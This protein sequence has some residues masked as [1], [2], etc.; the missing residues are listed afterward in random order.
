MGAVSAVLF[1]DY[2]RSFWLVLAIAVIGIAF[3]GV[4][5][6]LWCCTHALAMCCSPC[7][8]CGRRIRIRGKGDPATLGAPEEAPPLR[9]PHGLRPTDNDLYASIKNVDRKRGGR[10]HVLVAAGAHTARPAQPEGGATPRANAHGV[11]LEFTDVISASS[12]RARTQLETASTSRVH[13]CRE[14]PCRAEVDVA[15]HAT[16]YAPIDRDHP[17]GLR[18]ESNPTARRCRLSIANLTTCLAWTFRQTSLAGYRTGRG[19]SRLGSWCCCCACRSPDDGSTPGEW[20]D[21][22]SESE[23]EP[24][25]TR[26]QAHLV[27]CA[28][29]SSEATGFTSK[30]CWDRALTAPT[31]L[32]E[33]DACA[34]GLGLTGSEPGTARLCHCHA[35]TY[36]LERVKLKC[37]YQAC[38]QLGTV[39]VQGLT[40]CGEH[41]RAHLRAEP[42][43]QDGARN[44]LP[45]AGSTRGGT[46]TPPDPDNRLTRR[47]WGGRKAQ[48]ANHDQRGGFAI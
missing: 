45:L 8:C 30:R 21:S 17:L 34:S 27:L 4:G 18:G 42:D 2:T 14:H 24:E 33:E 26:C 3:A 32:I 38:Y 5:Y 13:L 28:G 15:L 16:A 44:P 31:R 48:R 35:K 37:A 22:L 25:D 11:V 9:G 46:V 39:H 36:E 43:P 40:L 47:A 6:C 19:V 10:P 7:R 1:G 23:S 41:A 12:R 29:Y 20:K